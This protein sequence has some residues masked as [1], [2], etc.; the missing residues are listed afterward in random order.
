M[1][2]QLRLRCADFHVDLRVRR[3]HDRF[4][5]SA[6]TPDGPTLGTGMSRAEAI[7]A[8]LEPYAEVRGELLA[9]LEA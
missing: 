1:T 2:E 8:A 5:A 7:H 4:L 9:S 3:F 6:D